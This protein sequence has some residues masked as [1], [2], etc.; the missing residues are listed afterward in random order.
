MCAVPQSHI[1]YNAYS[2]QHHL[3]RADMFVEAVPVDEPVPVVM[4]GVWHARVMS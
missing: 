3:K 4:P 1:Q 2:A